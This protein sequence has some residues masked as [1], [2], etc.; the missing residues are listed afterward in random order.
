[1][2]NHTSLTS[3][4]N[5]RGRTDS[6]L[7]TL[8]GAVGSSLFAA[9]D[10]QAAQNGWQITHR[11]GGL[12]RSYRDPRFDTL[13]V[14]PRCD[15]SGTGGRDPCGRDPCGGCGGTGRT[16]RAASHHDDDRTAHVA[17]SEGDQP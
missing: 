6:W 2:S 12:G 11:Q 3:E 17:L 4:N 8:I 14:C 13:I 1:V 7:T 16:T 15:G 9:H 10:Q 5:P